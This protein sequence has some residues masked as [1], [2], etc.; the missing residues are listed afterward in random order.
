MAK[1]HADD[2]HRWM[3]VFPALW[4]DDPLIRD[5][6]TGDRKL[7]LEQEGAYFRLCL[8]QY[9]QPSG[10]LPGRRA[11]L[12]DA[13]GCVDEEY[14]R[15][16]RP[17][18]ELFFEDTG[19]G[20]SHDKVRS[21]WLTANRKSEQAR[22]NVKR[23]W[24]KAKNTKVDT[25]VDTSVHTEGRGKRDEG[26][27]SKQQHTANTNS[28][29]EVANRYLSVFD[30]VYDRKTRKLTD[31]VIKKTRERLKGWE[32]WQ[33]VATPILVKAQLPDRTDYGPEV[34]LRNGEHPRTVNGQTSGGYY[35]MARTW[36]RVDGTKLSRALTGIAEKAGLLEQLVKFGALPT[37]EETTA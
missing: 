25:E 26:V 2:S 23:R 13:V 18:L 16:I 22:E 27:G 9:R 37:K 12:C 7:T 17:V 6:D 1:R 14:D 11:F 21:L 34:F 8:T 4:L 10:R 15:I 24:G 20:L 19:V 28:P 33:V 35:W 32:P 36:E 30:A 31:D 3:P 29:E 5:P